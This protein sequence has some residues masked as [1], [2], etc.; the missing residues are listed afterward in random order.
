MD[1]IVRIGDLCENDDSIA[2]LPQMETLIEIL[3]EEGSLND[4]A[5]EL[6]IRALMA[7]NKYLLEKF[8][9]SAALSKIDEWL[10]KSSA[11]KPPLHERTRQLLDL[12][13]KLPMTVKALQTAGVGKTVNRLRKEEEASVQ[14]KAKD[15]LKDWKALTAAASAPAPAPAAAAP[16]SGVK[17]PLDASVRSESSSLE[18]R[19]KAA[20]AAAAAAS[21]AV[22][23]EDGGSLMSMLSAPAQRKA[24]IKPDNLKVRRPVK[25]M[26]MAL[27]PSGGSGTSGGLAAAALAAKSSSSSSLS[28]R[29]SLSPTASSKAAA[30]AASSSA[31]ASAAPASASGGGG[32]SSSSAAGKS[33]PA[34]PGVGSK[35]PPGI[36][37]TPSLSFETEASRRPRGARRVT[38][39][40][41]DEL[42]EE[43]TYVC[44]PKAL[45]GGGEF[46]PET[47]A[48]DAL[49]SAS[50]MF[51]GS[52]NSA[53]FGPGASFGVPGGGPGMGGMGGG[54]GMGGM[55][56]GMGAIGALGA[57]SA[58]APA[59]PE[60]KR[61]VVTVA[62]Y[63]PTLLNE[64]YWPQVKG[65]M[66]TE[67]DVQRR[68]R[69]MVPEAPAFSD[70]PISEPKPEDDQPTRDDSETPILPMGVDAD[71]KPAAEQQQQQAADVK[72]EQPAQQQGG[73]LGS[74]G[75]GALGGGAGGGLGALGC[76]GMGALGAP[77]SAAPTGGGVEVNLLQNLMA[78]FGGGGGMANG[79]MAHGGMANGGMA[80]GGMANAGMGGAAM[81]QQS[82]MGMQQGMG[83]QQGA[84]A[85]NAMGIGGG[86]ACGG[87]ANGG[88]MGAGQTA[89]GADGGGGG[90]GAAAG[91]GG[92]N[93]KL[94]LQLA[95][96][97]QS[98]G[99]MGAGAAGRGGYGG[100]MGY[101]SN[102]FG[103]NNSGYGRGAGM[104]GGF[105]QG[106]RG[107]SADQGALPH[108]YR[109]K[110]CRYFQQGMCKNGDRCTFLH[111]KED[112]GG[113]GGGGGY[114]VQQSVGGGY[115]GY[116]AQ[117]GGGYGGQAGCA[118]LLPRSPPTETYPISPPSFF[119][120]KRS[121]GMNRSR[122]SCD[123]PTV[124]GQRF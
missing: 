9:H 68:R 67:R 108:N 6:V 77:A 60:R 121:H 88:G 16:A 10:N 57:P 89:G 14:T 44:E 62:W 102:G 107:A 36:A 42:V 13:K 109:T 63:T 47:E 49:K 4:M 115:P 64:Q 11:A 81:Q 40:K 27:N 73:L 22:N 101:M 95:L 111:T 21:T 1:L 78:Q 45:R 80:N 87:M 54:P 122:L 105:Q 18:K 106:G 86:G 46:R 50:S 61:P 69:S 124:G 74:A 84:A 70:A 90:G 93:S 96:Q 26:N 55:G 79:G 41:P 33:A 35:Q 7:T 117:Q 43:R 59:T 48:R 8:T 120:F 3:T 30:P 85:G 38:W 119:I 113:G 34:T 23:D 31:A 114:G 15:L 98:T 97:Q 51:D 71:P 24:S 12:L 20:A 52:D 110:P 100:G 112:A 37:V 118:W 76:G 65:D 39:A 58:A 92:L 104:M 29:S 94:A 82:A 72:L 2:G 116:G 19:S 28:P 66:S 17:R 5:E 103:N 56:M 83:L 99:A 123:A 32:A 53:S 25:M 75:L 91:G